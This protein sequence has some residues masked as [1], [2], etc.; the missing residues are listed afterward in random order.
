MGVATVLLHF[1]GL[2][3]FMAEDTMVPEVIIPIGGFLDFQC[4]AG[5]T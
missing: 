3:G 4:L 2:M 1:G 5:L